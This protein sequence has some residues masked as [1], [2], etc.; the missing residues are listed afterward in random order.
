MDY[1]ILDD[2]EVKGLQKKVN[3]YIEKGYEPIGGIEAVNQNDGF[4]EYFQS[5]IKVTD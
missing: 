1:V 3:A 4:I 2:F 5:M